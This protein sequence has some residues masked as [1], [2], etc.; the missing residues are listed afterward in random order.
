[1][2]TKLDFLKVTRITIFKIIIG[3]LIDWPID[4]CTQRMSQIMYLSSE[5]YINNIITVK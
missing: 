4:Y 2:S 1:M 3:L 5:K